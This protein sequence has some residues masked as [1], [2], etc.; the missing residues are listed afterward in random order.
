MFPSFKEEVEE[1][2]ATTVIGVSSFNLPDE[3]IIFLA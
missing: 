1:E 3:T 2:L